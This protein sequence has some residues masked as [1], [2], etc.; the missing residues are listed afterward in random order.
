MTNASLSDFTPKNIYI[1]I[2]KYKE[3]PNK[4]DGE[5]LLATGNKNKNTAQ[6]GNPK[7]ETEKNH[8][9]YRIYKIPKIQKTLKPSFQLILQTFYP[10]NVIR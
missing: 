3:Q 1:Y 8:R 5:V 9:I 10:E 6:E 4:Q 7:E 2:K